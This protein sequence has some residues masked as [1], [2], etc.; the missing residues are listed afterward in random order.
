M[1]WSASALAAIW[2]PSYPTIAIV[3]HLP[4][5][6]FGQRVDDVERVARGRERKGGVARTAMR[7][8]LTLEDRLDPHVVGDRRDDRSVLREVEGAAP[9]TPAVGQGRAEV[10]GDV[11]RV[12]RG[13]AVAE[14]Q[15]T[16]ARSERIVKSGC[17]AE[18]LFAIV[19]ERLLAQGADLLGLEKYRRSNVG[20]DRLELRLRF[21][22]ER[23]EKARC[24]WV[25]DLTGLAPLEQAAVVEEDV[26]QLPEEVV[27][28]LDKL[29]ANVSVQVQ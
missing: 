9:L 13:A 6:R 28:R 26:N 22:E 24:A 3:S 15:E 23:V 14:G 12:G 5:A 10:R 17:R 19:S 27:E 29:L 16:T 18:Q 7:D 11:H 8:H 21:G 2:P 20:D 1:T 25:V 4:A